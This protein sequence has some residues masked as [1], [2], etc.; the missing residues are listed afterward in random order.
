MPSQSE[1]TSLLKF[2]K[3]F[4]TRLTTSRDGGVVFVRTPTPNNSNEVK[5]GDYCLYLSN[6]DLNIKRIGLDERT[7]AHYSIKY[8]SGAT[9]INIFDEAPSQAPSKIIDASTTTSDLS[10]LEYK[11]IVRLLDR[12]CASIRLSNRI[13]LDNLRAG[14][15]IT[16]CSGFI[17][18]EISAAR[19]ASRP[20]L[21]SL[22]E[23]DENARLQTALSRLNRLFLDT[24]SRNS[25][26]IAPATNSLSRQRNIPQ[27]P[28]PVYSIQDPF[29]QASRDTQTR[30]ESSVA[31]SLPKITPL[32][33]LPTFPRASRDTQTRRDEAFAPPQ[34]R[35]H[36]STT[37][38]VINQ[39]YRQTARIT[40][41]EDPFSI[42][43]H[44][45]EV[46]SST[47]TRREGEAALSSNRITPREGG[48]RNGNN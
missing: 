30:R 17:A 36:D 34:I 37:L 3:E 24:A 27:S 26:A 25:Q 8:R 29:H 4:A 10:D 7:E 14:E 38:A 11:K 40:V 18:A 20:L 5:L 39:P 13:V 19:A 45:H 48:G 41:H 6:D 35:R 23:E 9:E 43:M 31:A 2:A 21:N 33:K 46:P 1:I 22:L 15:L 16:T 32:P 28:P 44:E 42:T 12:T 47:A